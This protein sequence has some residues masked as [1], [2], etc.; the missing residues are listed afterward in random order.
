MK[1]F[2]IFTLIVLISVSNYAQNKEKPLNIY[3]E[4]LGRLQK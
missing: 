3:I 1:K 2:L 4:G